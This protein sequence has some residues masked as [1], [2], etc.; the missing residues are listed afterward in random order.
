MLV[1]RGVLNLH[2]LFS[3]AMLVLGR[4][5]VHHVTHHYSPEAI[6]GHPEA[7]ASTLSLL[8]QKYPVNAISGSTKRLSLEFGPTNSREKTRI[9][10]LGTGGSTAPGRGV[11]KPPH[12]KGFFGP[13]FQGPACF[14]YVGFRISIK[15]LGVPSQS[16]KSL[17]PCPRPT[18]SD[19]LQ[20]TASQKSTDLCQIY[21]LCQIC[22]HHRTLIQT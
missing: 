16:W 13:I 7:K 17:I 22:C 8:F 11:I 14:F 19:D 9:F 4:V 15:F 3:G 21:D 12:L 20:V 6:W 1:F 5:T 10:I 2:R 18:N